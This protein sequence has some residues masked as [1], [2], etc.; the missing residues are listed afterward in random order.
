M[1]IASLKP[2]GLN[3]QFIERYALKNYYLAK[4]YYTL[5]ILF[6]DLRDKDPIIVFQMGKVGSTSIV[7]SLQ[8]LDLGR[9]IFHV[10]ALVE[11][12]RKHSE[13]RINLSPRQ[14]FK[15]SKNAL[16]SQYLEKEIHRSRKRRA[17]PFKK[18]WKVIT[19]IRDPVA[20]NISSFFQIVDL[21]VKD[22]FERYHN[23]QLEIKDLT[24][25]FLEQYSPDCVFNNWFDLELKPVFDIDVYAN[26]FP[27][28]NGYEIYR[29]E[30]ADVLLIKL[31]NLNQ[32]VSEAFYHFLGLENFTLINK[33]I[34]QDKKYSSAYKEFKNTVNLPDSYINAI[35]ALKQVQHFYTQEEIEGFKTK[36]K[37]H[38]NGIK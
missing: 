31:E 15:R 1:N 7:T 12:H 3:N 30:V 20:Q 16:I 21:Y 23:K 18:K 9:P 14:Y 29:G 37:V 27:K 22:V 28:A 5:L 6:T 17:S 35:Y 4:L 24:S 11:A 26:T 13:V 2:F 25:L 10:H 38:M 19:L 34:A 36:L 33:N 8:S 32:C